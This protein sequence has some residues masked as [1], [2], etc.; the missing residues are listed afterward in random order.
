MYA[1]RGRF[2]RPG[3][4]R[5]TVHAPRRAKSPALHDHGMGRTTRDPRGNGNHGGVKTPPYVRGYGNHAAIPATGGRRNAR[6]GRIHAAPTHGGDV[7]N[8]PGHGWPTHGKNVFNNPRPGPPPPTT[9]FPFSYLAE[10]IFPY[11][12][13]IGCC[14]AR[15]FVVYCM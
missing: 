14:F 4:F 15:P 7:F 13:I 11:F 2:L 5:V 8:K 9:H 6:P 1:A 3:A 10:K 12:I